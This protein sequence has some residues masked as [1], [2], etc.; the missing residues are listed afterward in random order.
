MGA[1]GHKG[2]MGTPGVENFPQWAK[3]IINFRN[4]KYY[5]DLGKGETFN[6]IDAKYDEIDK[7]IG[8]MSSFVCNVLENTPIEEIEKFLRKKKLQ[9]INKL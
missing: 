9:K 5:S 2:P 4:D 8:K 1:K 7:S 3:N 6:E